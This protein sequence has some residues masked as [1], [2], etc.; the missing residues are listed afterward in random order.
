MNHDKVINDLW[1][2]LI[3]QINIVDEVSGHSF[4]GILRPWEEPI[5]VGVVD[6]AWE[7]SGSHLECITGWRHAENDM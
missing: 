5:Y 1:L 4:Q 2:K 7:R 6:Q 3:L